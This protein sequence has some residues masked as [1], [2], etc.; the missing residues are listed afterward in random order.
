MRLVR[1]ARLVLYFGG[2][3]TGMLSAAAC[4]SMMVAFEYLTVSLSMCRHA[5]NC[6]DARRPW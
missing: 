1:L 5:C 4:C 2:L 6:V 3:G